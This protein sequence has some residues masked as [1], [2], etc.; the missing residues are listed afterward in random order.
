MEQRL[1]YGSKN[2][3]LMYYLIDLTW[4]FHRNRLLCKARQPNFCSVFGVLAAS[5][6]GRVGRREAPGYA[7]GCGAG[8]IE[9]EGDPSVL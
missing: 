5:V 9:G 8:G 7:D 6:G 3:S 2:F 4:R 1:T